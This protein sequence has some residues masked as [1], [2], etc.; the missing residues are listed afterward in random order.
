[1]FEQV[2]FAETPRYRASRTDGPDLLKNVVQTISRTLKESRG[3]FN[4]LTIVE[5]NVQRTDIFD[6]YFTNDGIDGFFANVPL[7]EVWRE[8]EDAL[9]AVGAASVAEVFRRACTAHI[10]AEQLEDE[11]ER[12]QAFL[13]LKI[14]KREINNLGIDLEEVLRQYVDR[15]YPWLD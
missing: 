7:P 15:N 10:A 11:D 5:R 13:A 9:R 8:T 2:N 3:D 6:S 14:F 1:M 4:Q 12:N